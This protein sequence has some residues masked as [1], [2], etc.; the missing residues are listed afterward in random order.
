MNDGYQQQVQIEEILLEASQFF[1]KREV[2]E[3]ADRLKI[4]WPHKNK[5]FIYHWA[6][7]KVIYGNE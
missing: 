4:L 1:K 7:E 5:L 6:F 2:E 3:L